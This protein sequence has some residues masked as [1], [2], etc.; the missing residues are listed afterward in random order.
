MVRTTITN[1]TDR[2]V[3]ERKCCVTFKTAICP[4]QIS[5]N[6]DD[7]H[8]FVDHDS[9]NFFE[10]VYN[11]GKV[12]SIVDAER[13]TYFARGNHIDAG[14]VFV[15]DA[16]NFAH[17]ACGKEHSRADNFDYGDVIFGCNCFD[18]PFFAVIIDECAGSFRVEGVLQ[19]H[20]NTSI[21]SWL[22]TGWVK[23]FCTKVSQFCCFLK[24]KLTHG[25]C[26]F[27]KTRVVVVHPVDVCPNLNLTCA[28]GCTDERSCVVRTATLEIVYLPFGIATDKSLRDVDVVV[29]I[30]FE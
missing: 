15:E 3:F 13:Y 12:A 7:A 1:H 11:G 9:A 25:S 24:T 30:L 5:N 16:E 23:N 22:N 17:K 20:G 14:L 8:T 6:A 26:A 27:N 10:F 2:N 18:A 4:A 19:S 21:S 29:R 28:N